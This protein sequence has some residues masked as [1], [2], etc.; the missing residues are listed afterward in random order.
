MRPEEQC[1]G[2]FGARG[3]V[4]LTATTGYYAML[5]GALNTFEVP[6][7]SGDRPLLPL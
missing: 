4:D 3:A 1:W 2:R 7:E 5:A 6:L